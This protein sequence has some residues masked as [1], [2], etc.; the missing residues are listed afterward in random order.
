MSH[1]NGHV[2]IWLALGIL[3]EPASHITSHPFSAVASEQPY[4]P[5]A[6]CLPIVP[7]WTWCKCHCDIT[8][9]KKYGCQRVQT[10]ATVCHLSFSCV[11]QDQKRHARFCSLPSSQTEQE[12]RKLKINPIE[13]NY[14]LPRWMCSTCTSADNT[15]NNPALPLI[16][17]EMV[18][19][20]T[21]RSKWSKYRKSSGATEG[22]CHR[23]SVMQAGIHTNDV[24]LEL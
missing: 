9:T 11:A 14:F 3:P 7:A 17:D 8:F 19:E 4:E 20:F 2:C 22:T 15:F 24:M 23:R 5:S 1:L 16:C 10:D 6:V 21:K 18:L 13:N 12:M